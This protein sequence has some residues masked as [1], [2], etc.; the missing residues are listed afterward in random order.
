MKTINYRNWVA[1]LLVAGCLNAAAGLAHLYSPLHDGDMFAYDGP[2]GQTQTTVTSNLL[3]TVPVFTVSNT[4]TPTVADYYYYN[5]DQLLWAGYIQA[6][7]RFV[8]S[9]SLL[10][11]DGSKVVGGSWTSVTTVASS[12]VS[13]FESWYMTITNISTNVTVK[14]GTFEDCILFT[15]LASCYNYNTAQSFNQYYAAVYAPGVGKIRQAVINP[16]G[17]VTGW[18]DLVGAVVNGHTVGTGSNDVFKPR[19]T[20]TTPKTGARITGTNGIVRVIGTASDNV[21]VVKINLRV[22]SNDWTSAVF[23]TNKFTNWYADLNMPSVPLSTNVIDVYA[24]DGASP[25]NNT[26]TTNTFRMIYA[27]TSPLTLITNGLGSITRIGFT[28]NLLEVGRSY[29]VQAVPGKDYVFNGWTGGYATNAAKLT[30]VM[31]SNLTLTANF[32]PNPFTPLKGDYAGLFAPTN[33]SVVTNSGYFS[34]TLTDKGTFTGKLTAGAVAAPISGTFIGAGTAALSVRL[35]TSTVSLALQLDYTNKTIH[36]TLQGAGWL[37]LLEAHKTAGTGQNFAGNYTLKLEGTTNSVTSPA[38]NGVAALAVSPAGVATV[39][40]TLADGSLLNQ[41]TVVLPDG[42]IPFYNSIYAGRGFAMG[43]LSLTSSMP[44]AVH[45]VKPALAK[46]TYYANGFDEWR[47]AGVARYVAPATKQAVVGW[48][49]GFFIAEQ[50]NL[51][52]ALTNRL[53][54]SNAVLKAGSGGLTNVVITFTQDGQFSGSFKTPGAKSAT[55][56]KGVLWQAD[57][58]STTGGGWFL[59]TNQAGSIQIQP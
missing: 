24:Q 6:G 38:G 12:S 7:F 33:H 23:S 59:G 29:S 51:N 54:V 40:G 18:Q 57:P 45:W 52:G 37:A 56:F 34:L 5:G 11:L 1:C 44:Q 17:T 32:V 30:F 27:V 8:P 20:V 46:E 15:G 47:N 16:S 48:T 35:G 42:G 19:L 39:K 4:A 9:T 50:G 25:T 36:G 58:L 3:N 41:I 28:S 55:T 14:A 31:Q 10:W 2:S 21:E 49:N 53:V 26:S 13:I 22:N 43:W